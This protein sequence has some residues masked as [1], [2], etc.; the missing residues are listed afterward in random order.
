MRLKRAN[1]I[2]ITGNSELQIRIQVGWEGDWDGADD[3]ARTQ[4]YWAEYPPRWWVWDAAECDKAE[5][6]KRQAHGFALLDALPAVAQLPEL[7]ALRAHAQLR[8]VLQRRNGKV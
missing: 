2:K 1:E 7:S 4:D 8:V 5:C 3:Q 6:S